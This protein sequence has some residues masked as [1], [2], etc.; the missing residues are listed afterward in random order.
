MKKIKILKYDC[1]SYFDRYDDR[2]DIPYVV[3]NTDWTTVSEDECILLKKHL[4]ELN[5]GEYRYVLIEELD[6]N[7][8]RLTVDKIKE[9]AINKEKKRL[10][11]EAKRKA[12]A[13]KIKRV[14]E[15]KKKEEELK[16]FEILK[17]KFE[18][19]V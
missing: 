1:H 10:E 3:D 13:E 17:K 12:R 9:L 8:T 6:S 14:A 15:R 11:N 2:V 18:G 16:T 7:E 19:G 4:G 5:V